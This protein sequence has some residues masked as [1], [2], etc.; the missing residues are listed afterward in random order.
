MKNQTFCI[1]PWVHLATYTDGTGLLCCIAKPGGEK[2]NLNTQT[3]DEV[4][5]S[6]YFK[7]A[8]LALQE[9]KQFHACTACYKEEAAGLRSHRLHENRFFKHCI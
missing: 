8:R 6:D 7:D 2:T 5:N 9:G 4:R 3:V 1:L